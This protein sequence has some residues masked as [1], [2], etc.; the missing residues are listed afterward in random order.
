MARNAS[1]RS[2]IISLT[3]SFICCSPPFD[4]LIIAHIIV[5]VKRKEKNCLTFCAHH[6]ILNVCT[7]SEVMK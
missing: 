5:L 4:G 6:I 2:F 1:E 3:D 7:K